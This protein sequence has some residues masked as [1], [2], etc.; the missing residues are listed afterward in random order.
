[1]SEG[2][3]IICTNRQASHE[4]FFE[5][6]YE[7]GIQLVGS[8]VKSVRLGSVNLKDS[9]CSIK[10]NELWLMNAYIKPYEKGSFFNVEGRRSRKLLA[11][12]EEINKMRGY[13]ERKGY[14]LVPTEVYL[15]KG[16]V[17]VKI[18]LA[19]GKELHDKRSV[20]HEK[21]QKRNI[22]RAVKEYNSKR[23]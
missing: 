23:G 8:E 6:F 13:V 16:L 1:M 18:A 4:Y 14:T 2:I 12:K 21:Q 20:E 9:F 11:H 10:D 19:K 5:G 17:K 22:E 3:K 7:V 15:K